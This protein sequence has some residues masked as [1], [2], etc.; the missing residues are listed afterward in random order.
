MEGISKSQVSRLCV[1]IDKRVH[2]FL[3]RMIEGDWPYF[4]QDATDVKVRQDH[5]IVAVGVTPEGRREVLGMA[6]SN[7]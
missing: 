2:A 1:E 6:V 7:T 5:H 4:W 3:A